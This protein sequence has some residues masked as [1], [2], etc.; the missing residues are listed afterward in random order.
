MFPFVWRN[1]TCTYVWV[2]VV[3]SQ[4]IIILNFWNPVKT[5]QER[6]KAEYC[7]KIYQSI[8]TNSG[9]TRILGLFDKDIKMVFHR[10]KT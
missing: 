6:K 5:Y 4:V 7:E 2:C 10:F 8:K 1:Y 3:C 9:S